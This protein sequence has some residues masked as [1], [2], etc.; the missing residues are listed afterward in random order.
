MPILDYEQDIKLKA[1]LGHAMQLLTP[2]NDGTLETHGDRE[3][4]PAT[5][6]L[7]I[8][9]LLDEGVLMEAYS[10]ILKPFYFFSLWN[11]LMLRR[12]GFKRGEVIRLMSNKMI[13]RVFIN[14]TFLNSSFLSA[15]LS[16]DNTL[17]LSS[18]NETLSLMGGSIRL[19]NPLYLQQKATSTLQE[20]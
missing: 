11:W 2:S 13:V 17:G 10:I 4:T 6:S 7:T 15:Y 16:F 14:F 20:N 9:M 1:L 12:R 5:L 18:Q 19:K 8:N 3:L